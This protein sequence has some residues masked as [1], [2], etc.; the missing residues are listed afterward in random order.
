MGWRLGAGRTGHQPLFCPQD[1]HSLAGELG[2]GGPQP[3]QALRDPFRHPGHRAGRWAGQG[4]GG[5][6]GHI[7]GWVGG[8]GWGQVMLMSRGRYLGRVGVGGDGHVTGRVVGGLVG[9]RGVGTVMAQ[10]S[11]RLSGREV[12]AHPHAYL[13]G[14]RSSLAGRGECDEGGQARAWPTQQLCGPPMSGLVGGGLGGGPGAQ[15]SP[16]PPDHLPV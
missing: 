5:G 15:L 14:H 4:E 9:G 1:S 16:V 13:S 10:G 8:Q 2:C 3:A 6:D 11:P 7:T 12:R